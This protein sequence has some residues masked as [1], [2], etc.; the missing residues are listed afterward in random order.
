MKRYDGSN[1]LSEHDVECAGVA[2]I[3]VTNKFEN[4][5][6]CFHVLSEYKESNI[7]AAHPLQDARSPNGSGNSARRAAQ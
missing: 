6:L 3:K 2:G 5:R 7:T 1:S 4:E